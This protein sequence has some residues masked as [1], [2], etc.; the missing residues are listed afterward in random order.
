MSPPLLC[1][2]PAAPS[3]ATLKSLPAAAARASRWRSS[4]EGSI[5]WQ[6]SS[7]RRGSSRAHLLTAHTRWVHTSGTSRLVARAA[8][9]PC[10]SS[11]SVSPRS[12]MLS[13]LPGGT[14]M[15]LVAPPSHSGRCAGVPGRGGSGGGGGGSGSAPGAAGAGGVALVGRSPKR[16]SVLGT[17]PAVMVRPS[18]LGGQPT[19][20]RGDRSFGPLSTAA[21]GGT[22][23]GLPTATAAF[24]AAANTLSEGWR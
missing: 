21:M 17:G 4:G 6:S 20:G 5:S 3:S 22:C 14:W 1:S 2:T 12:S 10:P 13:L 9:G 15:R 16:M 8:P 19:S 24:S 23:S 7:S 18:G 11:I